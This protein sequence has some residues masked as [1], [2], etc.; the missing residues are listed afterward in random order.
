MA[1]YVIEKLTEDVTMQS[2]PQAVSKQLVTA[3]WVNAVNDG[4]K[5]NINGNYA[6]IKN[7]NEA[8]VNVF[9]GHE[10]TGR[11]RFTGVFEA[12]VVGTGTVAELNIDFGLV[13]T[14]ELAIELDKTAWWNKLLDKTI[15]FVYVKSDTSVEHLHLNCTFYEQN[16]TT[17]GFVYTPRNK[18][19]TL[20]LVN[21]LNVAVSAGTLY[22]HIL[23]IKIDTCVIE[24]DAVS[25]TAMSTADKIQSQIDELD[26]WIG[27]IELAA[28]EA[29]HRAEAAELSASNSE[30]AALAAQ[31][32]AE[33]AADDAED[34]LAQVADKVSTT[35]LAG[36]LALKVD[37]V[38]G[39][40]LLADTTKTSYDNH[41]INTSNPHSV[42][43]TQVGL[44][45]V[46]NTSDANKPV[47]T[48][49]QT[50]LNLK[51]DKIGA[52]IGIKGNKEG[53]YRTGNVN[54]TPVNIGAIPSTEKSSAN[55]VAELGPDAKVLSSQLPSYVDDVLEYANFAALPTT[56]ESGKIY[57]TIDTNKTYRWSGTAYTAISSSLALGETSGTAYR[58]DRGKEAYDHVSEIGNVHSI[59]EAV[60]TGTGQTDGLMTHEDK[61]KLDGQEAGAQ[62]NVKPDWNAVAGNAQEILNK[63]VIP[64]AYVLPKAGAALGGVKAATKTTESVGVKIDSN[65][66]LF[67][68]AYPTVPTD[69]IKYSA[70]TLDAGQKAQARTN[71]GAGTSNFSGSYDDL[72]EKPTIPTVPTISTDISADAASNVKTASPKAVADYVDANS[73][74]GIDQISPI[75]STLIAGKS[76][77]E[78][79]TAN[80]SVTALTSAASGKLSVW[81][82]LVAADA[83]PYTLSFDVGLILWN[84]TYPTAFDAHSM[85]EISIIKYDDGFDR[86]EYGV[87]KKL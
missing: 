71:I 2:V 7:Q 81:H 18:T 52:V 3:E 5:Q 19:I 32:E 21:S 10:K 8:L 69:T 78:V 25:F 31:G 47:S 4:F 34:A 86:G 57:V 79:L 53:T 35:Q 22:G 87:W 59:P 37:K 40:S 12:E 83:I 61:A 82:I 39:S 64:D 11:S 84:D 80:K 41:L 20:N 62:S 26:A 45:N 50:A 36:E 14:I 42:T 72:S 76:Y 67:V 66:N 29:L 30:T 16:P 44:G 73:D 13:E 38:T 15:M 9:S 48:A 51:V 46:N 75:P 27:L 33:S 70:Q 6:L 54:I 63:P 24:S 49:Q 43:K 23:P 56:G 68:P 1:E 77:C 58:G 28:D 74:S 17:N 85:Y 65:G 60:P 55:G